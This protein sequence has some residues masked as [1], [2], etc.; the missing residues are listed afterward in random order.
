MPDKLFNKILI[1]NRG[2]IAVRVIRACKELDILSVAVY[3]E[4]DRDSLHVKLADEAIC[5]GPSNPK[6]SYLCFSAIISAAEITGADAIHPGYGFLSENAEFSEICEAN[7]ITFIGASPENIRLMGNKSQAKKTMKKLS[8]PTIP[9]SEGVVSTEKQLLETSKTVGYPLLLKASAG[10]GGKGMRIV[11][12]EK[13]LLNSYNAAYNEAKSAFGNGDIY[14]EKVIQSPRHIEIQVL[15]DKK[16]NA[17]HLGERECSIQ[18]RHQKLIEESPS[19]VISDDLRQAMGEAAVRAAVGIQYQGAGT[20]E[21]LVDKNGDF[22]FMEMNTRIQV[23]H[24]VTEAVT[25]IDLVKEQIRIAASGKLSI[26]QEDISM[27]GHAMEFR[28]NAEDYENNFMP[29][30]GRVDLFLPPG[31]KGVRT[32][33]FIYP[34]YSIP[35]HYDSLLGKLI[36]WGKDREETLK[37]AH[38][39]LEEFIIDGVKTTIPFHLVMLEQQCFIDGDF[40]THFVDE[41][42]ESLCNGK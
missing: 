21:F 1:A 19:P 4:A 30:P 18:R 24:P 3:S 7:N 35:T 40:D 5:I 33:S 12:E 25:G 39:A 27:T 17:I 11:N 28:I 15:S 29:C 13:D 32:D 10:G 23:E 8:V 9:G 42:L 31:G 26:K 37:R 14:V 20:V 6:Q 36:I 22:Y 2:E 34:G 41:N 16:K 38:R